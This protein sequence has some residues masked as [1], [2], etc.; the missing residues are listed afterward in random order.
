[1]CVCVC[2]CVYMC[3]L[4]DCFI[5]FV[6][7]GYISNLVGYLEPNFPVLLFIVYAQLKWLQVFLFNTNISNRHYSINCSQLSGTKHCYP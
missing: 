3:A 4:S 7:F 5:S 2:V 1:M 6:W